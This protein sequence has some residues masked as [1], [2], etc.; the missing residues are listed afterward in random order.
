ME[1]LDL[2]SLLVTD[3]E[4]EH[5]EYT[6]EGPSDPLA[7]TGRLRALDSEDSTPEEMIAPEVMFPEL[8]TGGGEPD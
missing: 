3:G 1:L 4:D 8:A 5:D 7:E 6:D 2:D